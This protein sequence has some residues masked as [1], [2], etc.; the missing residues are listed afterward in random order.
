MTKASLAIVLYLQ[1]VIAHEGIDVNEVGVFLEPH[2]TVTGDSGSASASGMKDSPPAVPDS[3]QRRND[4][5]ITAP[6]SPTQI[7]SFPFNTG[8]PR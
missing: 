4:P 5:V 7:G 1:S 2:S 8:N 3:L 6:P